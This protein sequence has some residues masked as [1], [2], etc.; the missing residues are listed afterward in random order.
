MNT[1]PRHDIAKQVQVLGADSLLPG[2]TPEQVRVGPHVVAGNLFF[3]MPDGST[4]SCEC[5]GDPYASQIVEIF[6]ADRVLPPSNKTRRRRKLPN[7]MT[8]KQFRIVIGRLGISQVA[9]GKLLNASERTARRWAER[10]VTG[11]A[12]LLLRLLHHG[13]VRME[14]LR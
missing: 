13:T 3:K 5:I 10:G 8:A 4:I 2:W 12:V 1:K 11:P 9:A 7:T 6:G 14:Q